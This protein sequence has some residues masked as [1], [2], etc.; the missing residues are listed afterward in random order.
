MSNWTDMLDKLPK[1]DINSRC[2]FML[3]RVRNEL[4]YGNSSGST[5]K[6][7]DDPSLPE[8]QR[9][10]YCRCHWRIHQCID[11]MAVLLLHGRNAGK[12]DDKYAELEAF[13]KDCKTRVETINL[14]GKSFMGETIEKWFSKSIE[15][16]EKANR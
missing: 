14:A 1:N 3:R 15:L 8:H 9:T 13:L 10:E 7:L 2:L 5:E 6:Y 12:P 4:F 16:L 11:R